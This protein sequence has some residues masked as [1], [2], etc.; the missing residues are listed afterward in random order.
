MTTVA[1]AYQAHEQY[2]SSGKLSPALLREPVFRA[3]ERSHLQGAS[4]RRA[5][6]IQLEA[7]ETERLLEKER[8]IIIAAKPYL[9]ALSKAAGSAPHAAMLGDAQAIV[10][11]VTGDE[12]TIHGPVSVPG[13]GSLLDESACGANGIGTPLAEG[14][15]AELAGPEH[16]I[17]GFHPF[18]CQGIPVRGADGVVA[19]TLSVSVKKPDAAQ[20]LREILICAAHAIEMD[21]LHQ[22]LEED[23]HRVAASPSINDDLMEKLRQDVVQALAIARLNVEFAARDLQR[24]R[25]DYA[26]RLLHLA[27]QSLQSFSRQ[28]ALWRSLVSTQPALERP[29]NLNQLI[30]DLCGLLKT[31]RNT[32]TITLQKTKENEAVIID[33]EPHATART[34][35]R[36]LLQAFDVA[37]GGGFVNV[38]VRQTLDHRGEVTIDAFPGPHQPKNPQTFRIVPAHGINS[39]VSR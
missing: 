39:N 16:F 9:R 20:F 26:S 5:K 17:G 29:V 21:L 12:E 4:A 37:R 24:G 38:L 22:R 27:D 15:Y 14:G 34:L 36:A 6:A 31:E 30:D 11:D 7:L 32:G 10:L 33:A 13:P 25:M 28:G 3:W 19:G 35:F 8:R 23:L 2:V 18:T 1:A